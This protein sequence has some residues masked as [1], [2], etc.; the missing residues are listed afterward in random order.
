MN[1]FTDL[2]LTGTKFY[3]NKPQVEVENTSQTRARIKDMKLKMDDLL[4]SRSDPIFVFYLLTLLVEEF[5]TL[6]MTEAQGFL[7]LPKLL[8]G[9]A[10]TKNRATRNSSRSSTGSITCLPEPVRYLFRTYAT[11]AEIR[12]AENSLRAIS[13]Q[14]NET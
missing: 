3:C 11:P 9:T 8:T 10:A 14:A 13:Q 7:V 12:E 4:F 1:C 5:D 2:C 6:E